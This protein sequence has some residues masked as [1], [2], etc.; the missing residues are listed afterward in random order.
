MLNYKFPEENAADLCFGVLGLQ[1]KYDLDRFEERRLEI[2]AA[3]VACCPVISAP[4][5]THN[6]VSRSS[7][8]CWLTFDP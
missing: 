5:V 1:D 3:L 6:T 7:L 2:L 4:L 8:A